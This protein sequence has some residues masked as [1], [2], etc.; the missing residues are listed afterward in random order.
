[1]DPE[2]TFTDIDA[3]VWWGG[4][5]Y[6]YRFK[7]QRVSG[8]AENRKREEV[9]QKGS[10]EILAQLGVIPKKV[11]SVELNCLFVP[12]FCSTFRSPS[13]FQKYCGR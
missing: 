13:T 4:V 2:R 11:G 1:M 5:H 7:D 12:L 3:Y 9:H 8:K 6:L 10:G